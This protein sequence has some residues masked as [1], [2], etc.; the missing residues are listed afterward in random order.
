MIEY[1][2]LYIFYIVKAFR[3]GVYP[4]QVDVRKLNQQAHELAKQSSGEQVDVV[5]D[6]VQEV[7]KRWDDLIEN[8]S[9]RRGKLLFALVGLGQFQVSVDELLRWLD[10]TN[11]TLD[12]MIEQHMCGDPKMVDIELAKLK[13]ETKITLH[14]HVSIF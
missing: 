3:D 5:M 2:C 9:E 1:N 6:P 12:E 10:R 7:N 8:I 14:L 11:N 13:V 4:K